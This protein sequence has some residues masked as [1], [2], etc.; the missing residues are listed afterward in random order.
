MPDTA[1]FAPSADEVQAI[2]AEPNRDE[3]FVRALDLPT[4]SLKQARAAV[5]QQLDI[6]SPLPPAQVVSSVVL[7]GPVED[8]LNRFAVGFAPRELLARMTEGGE[9]S[10]ALTGW[11]E[12]EAIAFRFDRPGA[13]PG[14]P[15]WAARL[16]AATIAG[17]CLAILLAGAS[18]RMGR[19]I[20]R[21]Q[22]RDDAANAQVQRLSGETASLTRIAAAWRAAQAARPAGVIDCALGDLAKATGGPVSLTRL[23]LAEG[24][25][26]AHLGAPASDA[27][28]TA[29]RAMGF[30]A[31]TPPTAA[32]PAPVAPSP[33][34]GPGD[35]AAAPVVR[36][37]Q[38]TA[39]DCR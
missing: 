39:A 32:S 13:P 33:L 6:L 11:L 29:L 30:R 36:D 2:A 26:S 35:P 24:Q 37:L 34:A 21:V 38:T 20:D 23:S 17:L 14:K 4:L 22:A 5:A 1:D 15:D 3:I 12:G 10:V 16:E 28:L 8:G 9:R 19:E 27:T 31:A 25:V 18:V 7:V